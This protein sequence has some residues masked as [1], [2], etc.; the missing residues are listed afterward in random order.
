MSKIQLILIKNKEQYDISQLVN[1]V[2]W[3]GKKGSAPR[4]LQFT[5]LNDNNF[6]KSGINIEDGHTCIFKYDGSEVF[7]GIILRQDE[8]SSGKK[9][10]Y[11]AYDLGIY[12][13]NNKDTFSFTNKR[14][15][16]IFKNICKRYGITAG[17][18]ANT[19]YVIG[20]L[21]QSKKK[22][23]DC[24]LSALSKTYKHTGK[25]YYIRT[26]K[27]KLNLLQ[28]SDDV[29]DIIAET[30]I[31][32]MDYKKTKSYEKTVTRVVCYND[33][34]SLV[35]SAKNTSLESKIGIFQDVINY[36]DEKTT[37]QL[38][39]LCQTTL[40]EESK[41]THSVS[42]SVLGDVNLIAGRCLNVIIKPLG[43]SRKF[44]IDSDDHTFNYDGTYETSLTLNIYNETEWKDD[45][46][47]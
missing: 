18:V 28:R 46:D 2:K 22:A 9:A 43:I 40:S 26:E 21:I 15:D 16:Q 3:S 7:R 33:D 12:L 47:D 10:T 13:S 23:W 11:K 32:I 36:D 14:A 38:K 34:N 4:I 5:L 41:I 1:Q 45:K 19:K 24:L 17:S 44:Y 30:G 37:A 42:I 8:N 20:E 35:T 25:R 39:K 27:G 29:V 31:N 6:T